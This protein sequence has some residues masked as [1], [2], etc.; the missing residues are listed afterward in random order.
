[1]VSLNDKV[2]VGI[3]DFDFG[4]QFETEKRILTICGCY[5]DMN[6]NFFN[7]KSFRASLTFTFSILLFL[8]MFL[9]IFF[10]DFNDLVEDGALFVI[11][12]S[13]ILKLCQ[14]MLKGKMLIGLADSLKNPLF[15][16]F[17]TAALKNIASNV[18]FTKN[19]GNFYRS[20]VIIFSIANVL[21]MFK[22]KRQLPLN[23]WVPFD[24]NED[25]YYYSTHVFQVLTLL[26]SG[27]V[28]TSMD[29]INFMLITIVCC[30]FDIVVEKLKSIDFKEL[31][32]DKT[33]KD[34]IKQHIEI[35]MFAH[36]VNA[37]YTNIVFI[38]CTSSGLSICLSGLQTL[39][40]SPGSSK[41]FANSSCF[42]SMI[43][44][45]GYYCWFGHAVMIKSTDVGDACY[46]TNWH[47]SDIKIRKMLFII[48]ERAK[49]PVTLT[50]GF[51]TLSLAT[52][53][54][55]LKSAYSYFA[56]LQ[57]VYED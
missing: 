3:K 16:N 30:Q 35:L 25:I 34:I 32:E 46:T 18:N 21:A 51:F 40:V 4:K 24:L 53:T 52:L 22:K 37:M 5:P 28:N 26:L 6:S 23:C 10:G 41:F 14:F 42:L 50:G 20:L 57:Q 27:Y 13:L 55:I 38:Q 33:L 29:I 44:Q 54:A 12:T 19:I 48:M 36:N 47:D 39:K 11:Q 31:G 17:S 56:L 2:T 49:I 9:L 7:W 15:Y 45:V 43:V 8:S 1:M